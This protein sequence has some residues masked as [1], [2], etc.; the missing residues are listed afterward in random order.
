MKK[1]KLKK[2]SRSFD[3]LTEMAKQTP[4]GQKIMQEMKPMEMWVN[5]ISPDGKIIGRLEMISGRYENC[6]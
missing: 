1:L 6:G 3:E 5:D 2:S 4:L